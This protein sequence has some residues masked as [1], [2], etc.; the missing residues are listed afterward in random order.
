MT[1]ADFIGG[2]TEGTMCGLIGW[3]SAGDGLWEARNGSRR[4]L[5]R[6]GD[7]D[8]SSLTVED[9]GAALCTREGGESVRLLAEA[10]AEL[11]SEPRRLAHAGAGGS[12]V[13]DLLRLA[14]R[15]T[16]SGE[17]HWNPSGPDALRARAFSTGPA[18]SVLCPGGF[19]YGDPQ[20]VK[21]EMGG[22]TF[23]RR[24]TVAGSVASTLALAAAES[25]LGGGAP[26]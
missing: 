12:S 10:V 18:F 16:E 8:V 25:Y 4:V 5:L 21:V 19:P 7:G 3:S 17:M 23:L 20:W 15:L 13:A 11:A 22:E 26:A 2:L 1:A 6:C 9:G 14:L 24:V